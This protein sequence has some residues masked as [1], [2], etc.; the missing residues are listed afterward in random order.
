MSEGGSVLI[1]GAHGF[2]GARSARRLLNEGYRVRGLVRRPEPIEGVEL[3]VGDISDPATVAAATRGVDSVVHCVADFGND[4]EAARK[5]NVEATQRLAEAALKAGCR[6]FVHLST[7]GVY[8]LDGLELVDESTPTF[9]YDEENPLVYGMT[10]AEGE[11]VLIEVA[12]C[13]LPTVV[14]RPP[15]ILGA[16]VLNAWSFHIAHRI[17]EGKLAIFGNGDNTWPYVHIDNLLDAILLSLRLPEAAG[18]SYTVVDG[19][20]TWG[21]YARIF[22]SW[23]GVDLLQ[24]ETANIYDH[25]RGRF[26]LDRIREELGYVPRKSFEDAVAETRAFLEQQGVLAPDIGA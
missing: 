2:V 19:H 9:A 24:R 10:K 5:V 8:A 20:T 12:A 1:T 6:R 13:G 25:F 4:V 22:A 14:L 17:K 3:F 15:N 16:D 11:R 21:D 23:L 18:R 26:A 7:C